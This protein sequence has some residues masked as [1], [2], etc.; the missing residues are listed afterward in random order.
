MCSLQKHLVHGLG[1]QNA[2]QRPVVSIND[3][4]AMNRLHV[5]KMIYLKFE[6]VQL[7]AI[8]TSKNVKVTHTSY[9]FTHQVSLRRSRQVRPQSPDLVPTQKQT[10]IIAKN[11]HHHQ[12]FFIPHFQPPFQAVLVRSLRRPLARIR[13]AIPSAKRMHVGAHGQS[14]RNK[15]RLTVKSSAEPAKS[16]LKLISFLL[17]SV[18]LSRILHLTTLSSQQ[19]SVISGSKILRELSVKI[20]FLVDQATNQVIHISAELPYYRTE[21]AFNSK[22]Y[23]GETRKNLVSCMLEKVMMMIV[24]IQRCLI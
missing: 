24:I 8:L 14:I 5:A 16:S 7:R 1:G 23:F 11:H 21:P 12:L 13:L 2:T 19:F 10:G 22:I 9:H 6:R 18:A 15:W 4:S 3:E 17:L 20:H